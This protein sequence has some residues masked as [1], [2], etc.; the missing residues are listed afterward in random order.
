MTKP[1]WI[2]ALAQSLT[3]V[4]LWNPVAHAASVSEQCLADLDSIPPFLL[5]NDAGARDELAALGQAHFDAALSQARADALRSSD[6]AEC[7]KTLNTYL[8]AWRKGHLLI[9]PVARQD[10]SF[11]SG[12]SGPSQTADAKQRPPTFKF[13]SNR[14]AL[15]IVPSFEGQYRES[16]QSLLVKHRKALASHRNWIIDVRKNDGGSD[17]TFLPLLPWL[18]SDER[19]DIGASWLVTKANI[20][21]QE[22]ACAIFAPGDTDCEQAMAEAVTRMR[23]A[24]PGSYVQQEDGSPIQFLRVDK[25][26]PRRPTRVAVLIDSGCG[27]SCEEFLLAI[28]QSFTVKLLGRRTRGSLDYS[29]LRPRLMPSGVRMLMYA[30]SRSNRLPGLPVDI[31]GIAPDIYLPEPAGDTE[32]ADEVSRVQR[33]LEGASLAAVTKVQAHNP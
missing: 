30:V 17:S 19:E 6:V 23:S 9:K 7:D 32:Y 29:N 1:L 33:W 5:E 18:I 25:L 16:L 24:T 3:V 15:L 10:G 20:E 2:S 12:N 31:A 14:T 26:E 28:R 21:G 22:K 13:L 27:S 8:R 11:E 4:F